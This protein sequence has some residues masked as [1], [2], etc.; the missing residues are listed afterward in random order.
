MGYYRMKKCIES[1]ITSQIVKRL[2][3]DLENVYYPPKVGFN[4]DWVNLLRNYFEKPIG[5][6]KFKISKIS[7]NSKIGIL[8][9]DITRPTPVRQILD[10]LVKL[11]I[12]TGVKMDNILLIHAP[13]LHISD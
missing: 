10:V 5:C 3:I 8:F 9:D 13:G 4:R 2:K 6:S 7:K 12:A 1:S 11:L